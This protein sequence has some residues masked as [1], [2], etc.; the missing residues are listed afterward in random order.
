MDP[1]PGGPKTYGSG[2]SGSATLPPS[3]FSHTLLTEESAA[4]GLPDFPM[5]NLAAC[6]QIMSQGSPLHLK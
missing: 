3:L 2:G 4:L 6:L 1:D 5:E